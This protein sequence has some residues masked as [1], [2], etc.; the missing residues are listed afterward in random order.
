M[1]KEWVKFQADYKKLKSNIDKYTVKAAEGIERRLR[2]TKSNCDEG[3][4]HLTESL[5]KA[6]K[7]GVTGDKLA[8]FQKDKDF[9]AA[10]KLLDKSVVELVA[11]L[12]ELKAFCAGAQDTADK[13]AALNV[14]ITKDLKSRKDKSQS[15]SD[16]E[17]L[18]AQTAADHQVLTKAAGFINKPTKATLG[19]VDNYKKTI[20]KI[21]ATA[22][23]EAERQMNATELPQLLVDRNIKSNFSKVV[24]AAKNVAA[25]C[26]DAID[27]AAENVKAAL[28][29]LKVAQ[30]EF[31]K[32]KTIHDQY[33][34]VSKNYKAA[35]NESKDKAK[36]EKMVTAIETSHDTAERELR[37]AATTIKKAG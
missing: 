16:I 10:K 9:S 8:D 4:S 33:Q 3:E 18:Q 7:N 6:R 35:I 13:V 19:Y 25:A 20:D 17:A 26:N 22:P 14:A 32:I 24:A 5:A 30:V 23:E 29:H 34:L 1:A 15:K 37:G 11:D 28:P 31:A 36:I 21:V 27:A 2:A 12:N